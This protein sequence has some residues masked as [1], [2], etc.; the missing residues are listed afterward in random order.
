[1]TQTQPAPEAPQVISRVEDLPDDIKSELLTQRADGVT[2]SELKRAF[3]QVTG[4]VI[5]EVL[6]PANQRERKQREAKADQ[7]KQPRGAVK[8]EAEAV[9]NGGAERTDQ[10]EVTEAD[11][12]KTSKPQAAKPEPAPK[13]E[14]YLDPDSE[15][16]KA[17]AARIRKARERVGQSTI[18]SLAGVAPFAVWRAEGDRQPGAKRRVTAEE[19]PLIVAA[20]DKIE[21]DPAIGGRKAAGAGG[22][23]PRQA[24]RA[25][26]AAK[27]DAVA[28]LLHAEWGAVKPAS[29]RDALADIVGAPKPEVTK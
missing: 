1:M 29:F 27:V 17:L 23:G 18:A 20:L 13:V 9:A 5:R 3:P 2:L 14:R 4:D 21:S 19:L 16:V 15:P 22:G 8:R 26:L 28:Q 7:P 25:A 10:G 12:A 6:P 24:T 11:A